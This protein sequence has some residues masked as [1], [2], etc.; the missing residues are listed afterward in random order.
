MVVEA[1]G[2]VGE[3]REARR[4]S[5]QHEEQPEPTSRVCLPVHR[6]VLCLRLYRS[7]G[8]TLHTAGVMGGCLLVNPL[9]VLKFEDA[10]VQRM[11]LKN[12]R[13]FEFFLG[14]I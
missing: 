4:T 2:L 6:D 11:T 8:P 10:S 14:R 12:N 9:H 13:N 1:N 7:Q 5:Q 3:R